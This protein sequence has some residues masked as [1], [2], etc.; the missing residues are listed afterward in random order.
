MGTR[1]VLTL[2]LG[3]L[4]FTPQDG[5]DG[6]P[7]G[8]ARAWPSDLRNAYIDQWHEENDPAP[9]QA[10]VAVGSQRYVAPRGHNASI[11]HFRDFFGAMRT[12]GATIED[13]TFG[14]NT[15]LACHMANQSY[16][17]ESIATWDGEAGKIRG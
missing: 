17:N 6:G 11:E 16:F 8:F 5:K 3:G 1:G 12:R 2:G 13:A 9:G 10:E 4:T 14:N 15:A 7:S